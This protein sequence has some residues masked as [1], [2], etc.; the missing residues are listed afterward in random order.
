MITEMVY[1][2]SDDM[3]YGI[4]NSLQEN[5]IVKLK[6]ISKYKTGVIGYSQGPNKESR[7]KYII[8]VN[9]SVINAPVRLISDFKRSL[10]QVCR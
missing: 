10:L 3:G 5:Y 7:T 2:P 9:K 8:I 1:R 4:I 6:I